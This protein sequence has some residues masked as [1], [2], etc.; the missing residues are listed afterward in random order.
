MFKEIGEI[1]EMIGDKDVLQVFQ[2]G[3]DLTTAFS[4]ALMVFPDDFCNVKEKSIFFPS[5]AFAMLLTSFLLTNYYMQLCLPLI[6]DCSIYVK[7]K[8]KCKEKLIYNF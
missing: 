7:L 4:F 2:A 5:S 8:P 1:L 3:R 6:L